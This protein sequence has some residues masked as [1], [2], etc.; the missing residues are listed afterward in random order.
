MLLDAVE[1]FPEEERLWDALYKQVPR[2]LIGK[3]R[4]QALFV[5]RRIEPHYRN[6]G[7][8]YLSLSEVLEAMGDLE[9]AVNAARRSCKLITPPVQGYYLHLYRLLK[10][11]DKKREAHELRGYMESTFGVDPD[12]LLAK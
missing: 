1:A 4:G 11:A 8:Y 10:R 5:L 6:D 9:G 12:Q 3:K 7:S 2:L